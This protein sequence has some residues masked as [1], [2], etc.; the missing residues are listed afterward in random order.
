MGRGHGRRLRLSW[1][2]HTVL[3]LSTVSEV[4]LDRRL[5]LSTICLFLRALLPGSTSGKTSCRFCGPILFRLIEVI[6]GKTEKN[7]KA[8]SLKKELSRLI[9]LRNSLQREI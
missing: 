6:K 4:V 5:D 7:I 3:M 2:K 8:V 1:E 9:S